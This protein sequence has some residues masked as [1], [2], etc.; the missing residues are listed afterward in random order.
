VMSGQGTV[1]VFLNG[2]PGTTLHVGGV[3]KLYTLFSSTSATSGV[4]TLRVSPGVEAY[5]FTFG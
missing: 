4:L 5:D 2:R 3:P 1:A